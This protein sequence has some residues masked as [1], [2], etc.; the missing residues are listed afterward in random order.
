MAREERSPQDSSFIFLF[1]LCQPGLQG[2]LEKGKILKSSLGA[3]RP[4]LR[5]N[6][7]RGVCILATLKQQLPI[8]KIKVFTL[9]YHLKGLERWCL[10]AVATNSLEI[11]CGTM[12]LAWDSVP[13]T[14]PKRS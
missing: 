1:I 6:E 11:P 9:P 12:E 7:G 4:P 10:K 8:A 5:K 3:D 14:H 13:A 2:S